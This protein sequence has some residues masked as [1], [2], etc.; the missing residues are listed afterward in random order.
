MQRRF[1][2]LSVTS[3]IF[4]RTSFLWNVRFFFVRIV[5]REHII[6]TF[7]LLQK[8]R[9]TS[10]L[11]PSIITILRSVIDKGSYCTMPNADFGSIYKVD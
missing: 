11:R 2:F 7:S 10:Q 3:F 8:L 5:D 4:H 6:F 9:S 1:L